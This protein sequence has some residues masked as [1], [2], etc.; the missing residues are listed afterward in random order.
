ME[1]DE[2]TSRPSFYFALTLSER[3]KHLRLAAPEPSAPFDAERAQR[4]LGRWRSLPALKDPA[5]FAARLA[6]EG[7]G[8]T[9]LLRLLGEPPEAVARRAPAV[10]AWLQDLATALSEHA[11]G[12]PIS[13]PESAR[14]YAMAAAIPAIAP[15]LRH[16]RARLRA[17]IARI[18]RTRQAVPF[19]PATV[20]DILYPSLV[21]SLMPMLSR[22]MALEVNAARLR[23]ELPQGTPEERFTAF[24]D[25]LASPGRLAALLEEYPVLAR[26][27]VRHIGAW[28]DTSVEFLEHLSA[29][30]RSLREALFAGRDPGPLVRVDGSMGDTHRGG[31]SVRIAWFE[32]GARAVHKPRPLALDAHF[33]ELLGWLDER[34]QAP[35]FKK[36]RILDRGGHGW[37]EFV[38]AAGCESREEVR[39]FYERQGASL[40]VLYL[41]DAADLHN[42]NVIAC[43]EHPLFI[44]LEA[45]FH[46]RFSVVA[47]AGSISAAGAALD[48]SVLRVGLLPHRVA[49]GNRFQGMDISG[50]GGAAGQLT[51]FQVPYWEKRGTDEV[52][53]GKRNVEVPIADNRPSLGGEAMDPLDHV[54]A[55]A[56]GFERAYRLLVA[57]REALAS[58][59]GPLAR[60]GDDE[61]RVILRPTAAYDELLTMSHH[62]EVVRD[63]LDR[64]RYFDRLQPAAPT[65]AQA[66]AVLAELADLHAGDIPFFTTR[67][68]SRDLFTSRGERIE[69]FFEEPSFAHV[70]RRLAGLSER[71]LATQL[72]YVKSS[73]ATL[74]AGRDRP[75]R[76][77]LPLPSP[78]SPVPAEGFEQRLFAAARKAGD[79]IEKTAIVA[80]DQA[81]WAGMTILEDGH[82][83]LAPLDVD[84]Y[85]GIPGV[86]LFLGALGAVTGE[87]RYS[88]LARKATRSLLARAS[89]LADRLG[90]VGGL[91]GWGGI[92][93]VLSRLGG[94]WRDQ[95][96]L[97]AAVGIA[98]R[99]P[100]LIRRDVGLDL[101][102]GAA[103][104]ALG[105]LALHREAPAAEVLATASLCGDRLLD[106]MRPMERGI[107]WLTPMSATRPLC[108]LSHG[109]AGMALALSA[110]GAETGQARFLR[111]ARDAVEYETSLF[112]TERSNWPD[113]RGDAIPGGAANEPVEDMVTWCHGAPGIGLARLAMLDH[114]CSSLFRS[115]I[116][117]AIL[118]TLERGFGRSHSLCHGDA[119]NLDFLA[120]AARALGYD[121]LAGRVQGA[122]A[123]LIESIEQDGFRCGILPGVEAPGLMTGIAG[124]GYAF[125]RLARPDIVP[126]VL[127][128]GSC[129]PAAAPVA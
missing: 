17:E 66:R 65:P 33:Q 26:R 92:V 83:T 93:Y 98:M 109:A 13:I 45:L 110:L 99:L 126:P 61:I 111:A 53:L 31:R 96:I 47:P 90:S 2:L 104:C 19:D 121:A 55:I 50:L 127:T 24:F 69:G 28:V 59:S 40:A 94:L 42:E 22:V 15:L 105:L 103:G 84:L 118:T 8:E 51:P 43:G 1:R 7:I 38:P 95:E 35:P 108:G 37:V 122:A 52:H 120:E 39:R 78:R 34:G 123:A 112:S 76:V 128:L 124:I 3:A 20:I 44:D 70:Q 41:L 67:P 97:D 74:R 29:D 18:V 14:S 5:R 71:D 54:D 107:A 81:T 72:R 106:T 88:A 80:G 25:E 113:F 101:M 32:S 125:L 117:T 27:L 87:E 85:S 60:F 68:T 9:D 82:W 46:P 30:W 115:D 21:P 4:R 114:G 48:D 75:A 79:E 57:N 119:G 86:A 36:L 58:P 11:A 102:N 16:G 91:T 89:D 49:T 10:P 77:S 116:D 100:E 62:P 23:G 129:P 6:E 64:D 12:E 73:L 63:A 56:A